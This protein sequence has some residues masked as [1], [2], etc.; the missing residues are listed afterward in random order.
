M[1][2]VGIAVRQ[3]MHAGNEAQVAAAAQLLAETRR[4][5]YRVLADDEAPPATTVASLPPRQVTSSSLAGRLRRPDLHT[6]RDGGRPRRRRRGWLER[7]PPALRRRDYALLWVALLVEGL[8]A[9]MVAVAVGWQVF[10]IHHSRARPRPDRARRVRAAAAA[11]ASGRAPRRPL[12]APAPSSRPRSRSR[13]SST[14]LPARRQPDRR[15]PSSGRSSCSPSAIGVRDRDRQRRAGARAAG[16]ARPVRPD[17]ERD[18]AAL[19]RVP[20]RRSSAGP[21]SAACSSRSRPSSST[22]PPRC[23]S[24]RARLRRCCMR[25]PR[26]ASADA[27]RRAGL[28]SLLAGFRFIRRTPVLLGAITLD[29]FAVLLRRR[30]RAAAASSPSTILHTGPVGLGMLR[31]APAVGALAR[32]R[33]LARR[34]LRT[35]AGTTL[36]VVVARVRREH[37]RLRALDTRC[38]SRCSRSRSAASST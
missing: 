18:G 21:R 25:E 8:G 9:Q 15:A 26:A 6:G 27:A 20:D 4:S 12:L 3:V 30:G 23:C 1:A 14:L 38:R 29:L 22:A 2:Q 13:S 32:R 36:L 28:D 7:L 24:R 19:D 31:S 17:R 34:P 33:L 5:L 10:A 37:G 35:N 16:D 11:R